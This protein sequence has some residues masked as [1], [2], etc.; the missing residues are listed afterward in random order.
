MAIAY[1][2]VLNVR[3]SR[4]HYTV[5]SDLAEEAG[6]PLSTLAR[7]ILAVHVINEMGELH[8]RE[9]SRFIRDEIVKLRAAEELPTK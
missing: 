9:R 5:L 7:R 2:H 3:L 8:G 4:E 1:P 6:I